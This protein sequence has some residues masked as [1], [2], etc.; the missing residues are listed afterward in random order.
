MASPSSMILRA[1]QMTGEKTVGD[2][3]TINEQNLYLDVLN[4]MLASW[5]LGKLSCYQQIIES[6][7]LVAGTSSY[8]IGVGGTFNTTRPNQIIGAYCRDTANVDYPVELITDEQYNNI[9][10]KSVGN[11]YPSYLRYDNGFIA[12]LANISLYP[13]P[14]SGLTIYL[15]SMRQLT[16][17]LTINEI[18]SL[19]PGYQRAIESNLAIEL[20][21]G[22]TQASKEL[23][24]VA[25]E[26]KAAIK[27]LNAP[28]QIMVLAEYVRTGS[29]I[30]TG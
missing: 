11:T 12:G 17:F 21:I 19:P 14:I 25:K 26:S 3:L 23:I 2:T 22:Q 4:A 28:S 29:S 20:C 9:R 10:L 15:S 13:K 24:M 8:T 18:V 30:F 6:F 7:P 1:L 16:Q 5:S 27:K